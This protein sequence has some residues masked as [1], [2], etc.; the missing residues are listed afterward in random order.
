MDVLLNGWA[1]PFLTPSADAQAGAAAHQK[2][3]KAKVDGFETVA[4]VVSKTDPDAGAALR[5][6]IT[7]WSKGTRPRGWP[8]IRP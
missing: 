5:R 3:M 6:E 4:D 7:A 2:M 8:P 1:I